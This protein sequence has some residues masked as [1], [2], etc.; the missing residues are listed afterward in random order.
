MHPVKKLL[1]I[2]F[3]D[4]QIRDDIAARL[5]AGLV[6]PAFDTTVTGWSM[7]KPVERI[8]VLGTSP[9]TAEAD[10]RKVFGQ[11]G[12]V[13]DSQKGYISKKLPGCTNGIWT[14]KLV[15]K[16]GFSLPPFL[17]MKDEGEVWQ[18]ATG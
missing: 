18:L 4:Q 8:R 3:V 12:E 17:I 7:D 11:Y 6:W 13:L 1:F 2:K 16:D 15:L 10:I 9:E 5:Q 14:V